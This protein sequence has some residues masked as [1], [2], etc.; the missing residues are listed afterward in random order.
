MPQEILSANPKIDLLGLAFFTESLFGDIVSLDT[1]DQQVA[2]GRITENEAD[3]SVQEKHRKFITNIM[4][5]VRYVD[6]NYKPAADI[7]YIQVFPLT[8][9]TSRCNLKIV[10]MSPNR[11]RTDMQY[12]DTR[13]QQMPS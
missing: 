3:L 5:F 6:P 10:L 7:T 12:L 4:N 13:F 8:K 11:S 2:L 1:Q 9:Q